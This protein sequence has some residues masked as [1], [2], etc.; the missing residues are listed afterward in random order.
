VSGVNG[1]LIACA[2]GVFWC[3]LLVLLR[4]MRRN[5]GRQRFINAMQDHIAVLNKACEAN[6]AYIVALETRL[7]Q[8]RVAPK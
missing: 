1:V 2:I 3:N 4:D 7:A 5:S 6:E 8:Y